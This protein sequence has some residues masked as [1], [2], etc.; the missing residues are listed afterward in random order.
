MIV[1]CDGFRSLIGCSVGWDNW[2]RKSALVLSCYLDDSGEKAERIITM[3][4]Y[5]SL[6]SEWEGFE[7]EARSFLDANNIPHFHTVDFHHGRG[8]FKG[9]DWDR[10]L[11]FAKNLFDILR[12]HLGFGI[13][14][15][16]LKS[17][18]HAQK[19]EAGLNQ[20][21]S[22]YGF[23]FLGVLDRL[24]KH[25]GVQKVLKE[26]NADISFFVESGNK[27]DQDVYQVFQRAQKHENGSALKAISFVDK[28]KFTALQVSDFLAYYSRRLRVRKQSDSHYSDEFKFFHAAT[29]GIEHIRFLATDFSG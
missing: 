4:G 19:A 13:E 3:A 5:F 26:P 28:K 12:P 16:T 7:P 20:N 25:E 11:V 14:F 23:C 9:W 22:A 8:C 2:S 24:K 6:A 18:Y 10:K 15:S 21:I 1:L 27:N 17:V 29:D